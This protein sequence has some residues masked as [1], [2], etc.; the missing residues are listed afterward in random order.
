MRR[1]SPSGSGLRSASSPVPAPEEPAERRDGERSEPSRSEA[2][3]SGAA[4][5]PPSTQV[6]PRPRRRSFDAAF[7]L[8]VLQEVDACRA[9]GEIGAV[10]RREGL[11]FGHLSKWREQRR[12]GALAALAARPRGPKAAPAE[13]KELVR[14]RRENERLR[15][16]LERA[17]LCLEIQK[18]TSE[19]LGIPLNPPHSDG[20][21][22]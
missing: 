5:P 18:K 3:S 2:G 1:S 11:Y 8:R 15:R 16:Q 4:A 13:S 6:H 14:L 10:L 12:R 22:S 21:A 7:K 20:S 9:P 17:N 19:L